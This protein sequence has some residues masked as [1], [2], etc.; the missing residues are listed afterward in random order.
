MITSLHHPDVSELEISLVHDGVVAVLAD[1]P[2]HGGENFDSTGFEDYAMYYIDG[3]Y[4]PYKGWWIPEDRLGHFRAT[5]PDGPWTLQIMDFGSGGTKQTRTLDGWRL[6]FLV[7]STGG[8]TGIPAKEEFANFGLESIRPN[9][10]FSDACIV[11]KL[12]KPG[13]AR[14]TV[15]N[16]LGQE[17]GKM[18]DEE[19]PEGLHER[20]WD[21]R[22]LAP[23]SYYIHLEADGMISVQKALV[24]R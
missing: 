11:F 24:V 22:A 17:V 10:V 23:G 8:G 3:G 6:D 13:H 18:A 2:E 7:S 20:T 19:F 15:Y 14:I 1:R 16:Q 12:P 21:P 9:P 5:N 4:A